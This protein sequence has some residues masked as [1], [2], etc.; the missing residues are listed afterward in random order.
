MYQ[1]GDNI[2]YGIHGV[3][4][5]V[6]REERLSD[7]KRVEYLVLEPL[8]QNGARFFV[9]MH[10]P[11]AMSKLRPVMMKEE[12][13]ALLA[14]PDVRRDGWI[15]DENQRKQ[16]YRSLITSSD[17]KALLC[18]VRTLHQRMLLLNVEGKRLHLCDENFLRDAQ[19]LLDSEFSLVLGV[20]PE[21]V[22][23]YVLDHM[24]LEEIIPE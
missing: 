12:L 24:G 14:S 16:H 8:E 2:L 6:G 10:N 3:C 9:P 11:V 7:R 18:M 13:D 23:G 21:Q 17:R 5:I 1:V 4:K 19:R 15:A 20:S 22:R